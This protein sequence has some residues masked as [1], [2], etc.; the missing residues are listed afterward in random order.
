MMGALV[1]L[2]PA[3]LLVVLMLGLT[4]SC[5]S[6]PSPALPEAAGTAPTDAS[7]VT[8]TVTDERPSSSGTAIAP[9]G[10]SATAA[11]VSTVAPAQTDTQA[12]TATIVGEPSEDPEGGSLRV[13]SASSMAIPSTG[14]SSLY[15][16]SGFFSSS[17]Q[18]GIQSVPTEGGLTVSAIG[19]LTVEADEAYVIIVP[20]QRYGP[21][22]PEQMTDDDRAEIREGL[23][24][25]GI[26]EESIEFSQLGPY[27]PSSISVEISLD[28]FDD[29]N[30][31]IIDIVEEV[32][33]RSESYGVIYT[34]TEEN[35]ES[36]LS[37]ARREAIPRAQS[38]ADDLAE[39]LGVER[40]GVMRALEYPLANLVYGPS[41]TDIRGCGSQMTAPYPNLMPF[42]ADQEVEVTVGLQVTYGIR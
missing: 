8:A 32:I 22:G 19:A 1:R 12:V 25:I 5:S 2:I 23:A 36:A 9:S 42:D 11:P 38:A 4:T 17:S 34:L 6:D 26:A 35:C 14:S 3:I 21:S 39:A 31:Q 18:P 16:A 13:V 40:G 15:L 30:D 28:E 10:E 33:R 37:L 27:G 29:K 41:L 7:P 24:E 20:E